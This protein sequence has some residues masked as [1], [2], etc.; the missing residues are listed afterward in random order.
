M[1]GRFTR[2]SYLA[3]AYETYA[4]GGLLSS[5]SG[6]QGGGAGNGSGS[7]ASSSSS[8]SFSQVRNLPEV[9]PASLK[10]I[11]DALVF[12]L[13]FGVGSTALRDAYAHQLV[14]N[15]LL[16]LRQ[17]LM[18][19]VGELEEEDRRHLG[20][21]IRSVLQLNAPAVYSFVTSEAKVL[22]R[23]AETLEHDFD[24]QLNGHFR[25]PRPPLQSFI[26]SH[27][28]CLIRVVDLPKELV[29]MVHQH[30]RLVFVKDTLLGEEVGFNFSNLL[31]LISNLSI[32]IC[33][34]LS[35][36]CRV[37]P[38]VLEKAHEGNVLA[39]RFLNEF[40]SLSIRYLQNDRRSELLSK[41][42]QNYGDLFFESLNDAF[43][44]CVN[45]S[46]EKG[47]DEDSSAFLLLLSELFSSITQQCPGAVMTFVVSSCHPSVG[48][49]L[50]NGP[51]FLLLTVIR[52]IRE[53]SDDSVVE[54]LS[55]SLRT[56]LDGA[57]ICNGVDRD[58]FINTVYE[59]YVRFCVPTPLM[60]SSAV[61]GL[62]AV[63]TTCVL[64]HS[65]RMK[66]FAM[67]NL[68]HSF[69]ILLKCTL[70]CS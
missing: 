21:I 50:S 51:S 29:A 8:S 69:L 24:P 1:Q 14:E 66:Y 36:D 12:S 39:F 22:E 38:A 65:Y 27:E 18:I 28:A 34:F 9:S 31:C 7:N 44:K 26:E 47:S 15:D 46:D 60:S 23:V 40:M 45:S 67:R 10:N 48:D 6:G 30:F 41:L 4:G 11:K 33:V 54:L 2:S 58:K 16:Y 19:K 42:F 52:T 32:D 64:C 70:L 56:L 49:A 68:V 62:C 43:A 53:S 63:L 55:E 35:E 20:A 17:L 61:R 5:S 37:L 25:R 59:H 3:N 13:T 57:T